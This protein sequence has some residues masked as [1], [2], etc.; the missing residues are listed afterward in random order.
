MDVQHKYFRCEKDPHQV[1]ALLELKLPQFWLSIYL[2]IWLE[3]LAVI[4][5]YSSRAPQSA[6]FQHEVMKDCYLDTVCFMMGLSI[7]PSFL[8][9]AYFTVN[10]YICALFLLLYIP[11]PCSPTLHPCLTL[12]LQFQVFVTYLHIL[13]FRSLQRC[14][15]T[16]LQTV[17]LVDVPFN[18]H[19]Y[20]YFCS[21]QSAV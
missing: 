19:N 8:A 21:Y 14:F 17:T 9:V 2:S 7:V 20:L 12:H 1:F 4:V 16:H 11:L 10:N 13:T 5:E 15:I 18:F 6:L 3:H